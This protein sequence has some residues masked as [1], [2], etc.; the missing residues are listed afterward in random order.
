MSTLKEF[1]CYETVFYGSI[2]I[3]LGF[4]LDLLFGDPLGRFHPVCLIGRLISALEKAMYRKEDTNRQK[5]VKGMCLACIVVSVSGG[6]TCFL[7]RGMLQLYFPAGI[8]L[9]AVVCDTT[10]AARDL[11]KESMLVYAALKK[12]PDK[13]AADTGREEARS[14]KLE[15]AR[16]AVSRI[17]GRDTQALD[18]AGVIRAA[19]ETVAE[20]TTDGVVAPMC[21][22]ILGGPT[23]AMMYKAI[24]TMD[25]MLGYKN[26]KYHFFGR[27]A[28]RL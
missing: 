22:L 1:G 11:Q 8:L 28:A 2:A 25:S 27:F 21:W 9:A 13:G 26:E 24:N 20:N 12:A 23:A 3:L 15:Q 4:I 14:A 19:V 7:I 6:I 10:L 18:E 16:H 5:A 17:V